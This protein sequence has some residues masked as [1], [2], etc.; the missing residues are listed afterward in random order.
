MTKDDARMAAYYVLR[1]SGLLKRR[2]EYADKY[3]ET[4]DGSKRE[5][6]WPLFDRQL[7]DLEADRQKWLRETF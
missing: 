7:T 1:R 5:P 2:V 4:S 3:I 6:L